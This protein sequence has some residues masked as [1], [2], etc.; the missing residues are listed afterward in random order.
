[1]AKTIAVVDTIWTGHAPMCHKFY[2]KALLDI[3][4]N[5]I[6]L[7]PAPNEVAKWVSKNIASV[8]NRLSIITF[9]LPWANRVLNVQ[10][11][12]KKTRA[13]IDTIFYWG[14]SLNI[15]YTGWLENLF[16][17]YKTWKTMYHTINSFANTT[18][19]S[20]DLV[21]IPWMD[22]NFMV[23]GVTGNLINNIFHYHWSGLYNA[24]TDFRINDNIKK[25]NIIETF[26]PAYDIFKSKNLVALSTLDEGTIDRLKKYFK[27]PVVFFPNNTDESLPQTHSPLAS[28][29]LKRAKGRKIINLMGVLARRKGIEVLLKSAEI[30][31][32][33]NEGY[34]FVFAGPLF[35]GK[36]TE[37]ISKSIQRSTE[38][39]YF[40][41]EWIE[42]D[43]RFNEL[44]KISDII[45]AAYQGFYHSSGIL[46]KAAVFRKPVIVSEGYCMGERV[47]KY[48]L[49]L[50]IPEGNVDRCVEAIHCLCEGKDY[51]GKPLEPD[52][53]R[54]CNIHSQNALVIAFEKVLQYV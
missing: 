26:L 19:L 10:P 50:T 51:D 11:N 12:Q 54:F 29:I 52:Y 9:E 32:K 40:Y 48:R 47:E 36:E 46:T 28:E 25:K 45:F 7:S 16:Y 33:S 37:Y 18:G 31:N 15:P 41:T 20:P 17:T 22:S 2:I 14:K 27:K 49:G 4:G 38:N 34:Y 21:F 44:I 30:L 3:G 23:T 35:I 42:K 13:L 53:E 5:V 24:P 8:E 43:E 6:S 39:C 1:M